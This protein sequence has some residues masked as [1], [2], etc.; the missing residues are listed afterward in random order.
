MFGRPWPPSLA[1][2][3]LYS[4]RALYLAILK[5]KDIADR[6]DQLSPEVVFKY[7]GA[8]R[9]CVSSIRV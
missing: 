5:V 3:E 7:S 2:H 1:A 4:E 8:S 6:A 9:G